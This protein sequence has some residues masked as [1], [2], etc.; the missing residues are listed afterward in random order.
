VIDEGR[1][2]REVKAEKV[3]ADAA[4]RDAAAVNALPVGDIWPLRV[5]QSAKKPSS[6][7]GFDDVSWVKLPARLLVLSHRSWDTSQALPPR[8]AGRAV[9]T[10]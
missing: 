8:A 2:P 9:L 1:D 4:K 5:S 10:P 3:V 7:L 6:H